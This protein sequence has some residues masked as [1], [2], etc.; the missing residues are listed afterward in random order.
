MMRRWLFRLLALVG[1]VLILVAVVEG[2][3]RLAGV[4]HPSAFWVPARIGGRVLAVDNPYFTWPIFGP[5]RARLATPFALPRSK[6]EGV[7]RV[8]Q[9]RHYYLPLG[10]GRISDNPNLVENP[11]Y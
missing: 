11:G 9:E 6:A 5:R 3:L 2:G 8:F 1:P 10:I 7:T 4:G